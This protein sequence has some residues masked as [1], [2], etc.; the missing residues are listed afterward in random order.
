[1]ALVHKMGRSSQAAILEQTAIGHGWGHELRS[2]WLAGPRRRSCSWL[3]ALLWRLHAHLIRGI[4][5][6]YDSLALL[7]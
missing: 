2:Y 6:W 1:M 4:S 7:R 3:H 5:L